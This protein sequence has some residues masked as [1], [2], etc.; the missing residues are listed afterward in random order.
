[1]TTLS[2]CAR[3]LAKCPE[4]SH[5]SICQHGASAFALP[6]RL[7][8]CHRPLRVT[9]SGN[10][11]AART[12]SPRFA[13]SFSSLSTE[14]PAHCSYTFTPVCLSGSY[15]TVSAENRGRSHIPSHPR[16]ELQ[17]AVHRSF[18]VERLGFFLT[19]I[20]PCAQCYCYE[21]DRPHG[22]AR[23]GDSGTS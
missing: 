1:M 2:Y 17:V 10:R 19:R 18:F 13:A 11:D 20:S 3:S 15:Q 4:Q 6:S 8:P 22:L 16:S 12:R 21:S 9:F 5:R 23:A 14:A 7:R